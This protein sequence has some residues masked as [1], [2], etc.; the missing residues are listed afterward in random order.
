MGGVL[1]DRGGAGGCHGRCVLEV[2]GSQELPTRPVVEGCDVITMFIYYFTK[3]VV[4]KSFLVLIL[5]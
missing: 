5:E 4:R 3:L 2:Q 1:A